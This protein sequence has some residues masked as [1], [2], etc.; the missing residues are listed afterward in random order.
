MSNYCVVQCSER[1]TE[2]KR[3]KSGAVVR[4]LSTHQCGP[5][6][7]PVVDRPYMAWVCCQFSPIL[8][9]IILRVLQFP[10][11]HKNNTFELQFHLER[12]DTTRF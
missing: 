6:E 8:R 12:T 4:A 11:L 7:N 1:T 3:S 2:S 10:P 9:E 5:G